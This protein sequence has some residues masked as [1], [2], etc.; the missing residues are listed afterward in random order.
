MLRAVQREVPPAQ[1]K[2]LLASELKKI[3]TLQK[4]LRTMRSIT[5]FL[6]EEGFLPLREHRSIG[7]A[8]VAAVFGGVTPIRAKKGKG[9]ASFHTKCAFFAL[10]S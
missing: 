10:S 3:P 2:D 5:L 8:A 6:D 9:R 4:V 7:I 1:E